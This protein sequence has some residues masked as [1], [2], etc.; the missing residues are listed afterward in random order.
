[1]KFVAPKKVKTTNFSPSA[2]ARS[3]SRDP[4][5]RKITIQDSGSRMDKHTGSA[6]LL[7]GFLWANKFNLKNKKRQCR[8]LQFPNTFF[9]ASSNVQLFYGF[10]LATDPVRSITVVPSDIQVTGWVVYCLSNYYQG[11]W[12]RRQKN[13]TISITSFSTPRKPSTIS[14]TRFSSSRKPST[15]TIARYSS[16]RKPS[17]RTSAL[18]LVRGSRLKK[19]NRLN[20]FLIKFHINFLS[21]I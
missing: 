20:L 12:S 21:F 3:G 10:F 15:I 13:S 1:M 11:C 2:V 17:P 8:R 16:P 14:I 5:W 19:H 9:E 6:T 4:G 18:S 7:L